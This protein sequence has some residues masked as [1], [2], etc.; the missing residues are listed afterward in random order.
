VLTG[1]ER[2]FLKEKILW[3]IINLHRMRTFYRRK[4]NTGEDSVDL[5][6]RKD[7]EKLNINY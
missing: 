1:N 4:E 2:N 3:K 5:N 6:R 7:F